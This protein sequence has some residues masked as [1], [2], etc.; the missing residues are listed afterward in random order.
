MKYADFNYLCSHTRK[1]AVFSQYDA[2]VQYFHPGVK[3]HLEFRG[4]FDLSVLLLEVS[5]GTQ[6]HKQ[7]KFINMNEQPSFTLS[8]QH[9]FIHFEGKFGKLCQLTNYTS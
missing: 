4:I 6:A 3:R 8:P 7:L 9:C 5:H 2:K 1:P